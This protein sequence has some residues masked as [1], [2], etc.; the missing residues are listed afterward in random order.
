LKWEAEEP[1]TRG[2]GGGGKEYGSQCKQTNKPTMN[3][4]SAA[5]YIYNANYNEKQQQQ[6]HKI[7][8]TKGFSSGDGG[9]KDKIGL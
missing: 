5:I 9:G 3:E 7:Y 6:Q 2:G 4:P 1:K 8:I